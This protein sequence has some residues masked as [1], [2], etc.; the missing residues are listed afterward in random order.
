[1]LQN[2]INKTSIDAALLFE[3]NGIIIDSINVDKPETITA[4][5]NII[6]EMCQGLVEE[7]NE[8]KLNQVILKGDSLLIIGTITTQNQYLIAISYDIAKL[9]LLLKVLENL[10]N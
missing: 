8:K 7:L 1:M 6:V 3:K 4:M 10:E 2:L 9:G 5:S